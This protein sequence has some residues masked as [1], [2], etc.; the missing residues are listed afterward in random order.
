MADSILPQIIIRDL[1]LNSIVIPQTETAVIEH[2]LPR[3]RQ[4]SF[5]IKSFIYDP[6]ISID[7]SKRAAAYLK[8]RLE[9]TISDTLTAQ[10][11]SRLPPRFAE[12]L[13]GLEKQK[14]ARFLAT[15]GA[16]LEASEGDW[17][18]IMDGTTT[19][20]SQRRP[21]TPRPC[22]VCLDEEIDSDS[23]DH[24]WRCQ[25]CDGIWCRDCVVEAFKNSLQ[26]VGSWPLLC[27]CGEP[28]ELVELHHILPTSLLKDHANK[29][30]G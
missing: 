27:G 22:D 6:R 20:A 17:F 2:I 12:M 10:E 23:F 15:L 24:G 1:N 16:H 13:P 4:G 19:A 28:L 8:A 26:G 9:D 29:I 5:R 14:W 18:I 30:R 11:D 25:D 7:A 21:A 3:F